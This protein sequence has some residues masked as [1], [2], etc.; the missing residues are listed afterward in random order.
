MKD[1]GVELFWIIS[2][3]G[4]L[5]L[6]NLT[7]YWTNGGSSS[8]NINTNELTEG[9]ITLV[10]IPSS[11]KTIQIMVSNRIGE[12]PLSN[13]INIV[14]GFKGCEDSIPNTKTEAIIAGVVCSVAGIVIGILIGVSIAL[15]K[16]KNKYKKRN[17]PD[18]E[19]RYQSDVSEMKE[20]SNL[21]EIETPQN[22]DNIY[23]RVDES[24]IVNDKIE[25]KRTKKVQKTTNAKNAEPKV[26][27]TLSVDKRVES[28]YL[29]LEK[30]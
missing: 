3:N 7:Y 16:L 11:A 1:D 22:I 28:N 12:S 17:T 18:N 25:P 10:G 21:S 19:P 4:D 24:N 8:I 15:R 9:N 13:P 26:Y 5:E 29:K 6:T 27:E 20:K 14:C 2:D 30:F 23:E